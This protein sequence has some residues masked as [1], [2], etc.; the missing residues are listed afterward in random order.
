VNAVLSS[1][2]VFPAGVAGGCVE[3]ER[4]LVELQLAKNSPTNPIRLAL[5]PRKA[6]LPIE[7]GINK[8]RE[9]IS[10]IF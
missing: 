2:I 10:A 4:L 7:L 3:V 5:C 6:L 1:F 9:K 8:C